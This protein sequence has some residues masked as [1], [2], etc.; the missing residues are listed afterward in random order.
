M[1]TTRLPLELE[2]K[3][4]ELAAF[5]HPKAI[6]DLLLVAHRVLTWIEPI[7]YNVLRI[8]RNYT[9]RPIFDAIQS[10]PTRC[11]AV[12]HVLLFD[13]SSSED[14]TFEDL[15]MFLDL[16]PGIHNLS[17]MG[18]PTGAHLLIPLENM[19]LRRL[20]IY[21]D[22]LF[23]VDPHIVV[24]AQT[25]F[26]NPLFETVT[27]LNIFDEVLKDKEWLKQLPVLPALT[28]LA[29]NGR[30]S[31][32]TIRHILSESPQLCVLLVELD[33]QKARKFLRS[34]DVEDPRLVVE[35][36]KLYYPD[37]WEAGARG[38]EDIWSRA[39]AF[40][41]AKNKGLIDSCCYLLGDAAELFDN[42]SD[43]EEVE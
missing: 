35:V 28:H 42:D 17:L 24:E 13:T 19:G 3:I 30:P 2:R 22:D 9:A 5:L 4:F 15:V 20:G 29:L 38:G 33:A 6:P 37:D 14:W 11:D 18:N 25:D 8:D 43:A 26:K 27:H 31:F 10:K 23:T 16:C 1:D 39:D 36:D 41:A 34:I 12:G 32:S 40:V 7:L 21:I